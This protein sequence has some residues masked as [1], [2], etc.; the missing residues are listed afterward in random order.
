MG[1]F[2]LQPGPGRIA[3]RGR[4][5][6]DRARREELWEQVP[7]GLPPAWF[8][9][10]LRFLLGAIGP[11]ERVLD[12]G[13]GE[14]AFAARLRS[15]GA[16]VTAADVALEPLLR[17]RAAHRGLDLRLLEPHGPWPLPDAGFDAVWAGEVIEH[18]Q[19]TAAWLS[20]VRRVLRPGGRLLLSTPAHGALR[21]L[22][23]ALSARA[24]E[25][26]FDPLSDHLRFYTARSLARLLA[27]FR[28]EHLDVRPAGPPPGARPLLLASAVR[29]RW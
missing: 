24:F 23:L 1:A 9:L 17:A 25:R 10:R 27:D 29:A 14:G 5:L 4:A 2:A 19:D 28:F 18:V 11:D 22:A 15:A 6:S 16:R 13:C 20:E 7:P 26:H 8:D 21:R 12:L 3:E